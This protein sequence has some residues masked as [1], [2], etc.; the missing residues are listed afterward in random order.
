M[1]KYIFAIIGLLITETAFAASLVVTRKT[2]TVTYRLY[3][4]NT[5]QIYQ[6]S[7]SV[8]KLSGTVTIPSTI[9]Y[10]PD[11][12]V[13][14]TY[15]VTSLTRWYYGSKVQL[16]LPN[17][18]TNIEWNYLSSLESLNL[19]DNE[20]FTSFALN[21]I[22]S[23]D[24]DVL[25][26]PK[27][28]TSIT[29]YGNTNNYGQKRIAAFEVASDN[30]TYKAVNGVL[31]TKDG[32][33]LI[34]YPYR[35]SGVAYTVPSGVT[36]INNWAFY[37]ND[38]LET[39]ILPA[40]LIEI[41]KSAFSNCGNLYEC[42]LPSSLTKIGDYAFYQCGKYAEWGDFSNLSNL[43]DIGEYAFSQCKISLSGNTL[44]LP[45]NLKT[46]AKYSFYSAFKNNTSVSIIFPKTLGEAGSQL[47]MDSYAF[48]C[49]E[50]QSYMTD[51]VNSSSNAFYYSY[52]D[53]VKTIYIPTGTL[54]RY[55]AKT[56]WNYSV[57]NPSYCKLVESTNLIP[58][59]ERTGVPTFTW[60]AKDSILAIATTT[61]GADIYYTT[62]GSDPTTESTK[63]NAAKPI[64]A[65]VNMTV[66]AISVKAGLVTTSASYTVDCYVLATVT[67]SPYV[68]VAT[69]GSQV[70]FVKLATSEPDAKIYYLKNN[71]SGTPALTSITSVYNESDPPSVVNGN[72]VHTYAVKEGYTSTGVTNF[73][74]NTTDIT[75]SQP[76]YEYNTKD[77]GSVV[78]TFSTATEGATIYYTTDGNTPTT[79]STVY[80]STGI[81][82]TG[83]F[84]FKAIAAKESM[85]NSSV[86]TTNSTSYKT[87][88]ATAPKVQI[89]G[90]YTENGAEVMKAV[91]STGS[92]DPAIIAKEAY[93][94]RIGTSGPYAEY[95]APVTV[96]N[97]ERFYAITRVNNWDDS[98]S[99]TNP[100]NSYNYVYLSDIR[101]AQ[102]VITADRD[103]HKVTLTTT[104]DGGTIYYTTDGTVPTESSAVYNATTGVVLTENCAV[105]AMVAKEGM[106]HSSTAT[107]ETYSWFTCPTVDFATYIENGTAK[108]KLFLSDS[109]TVSVANM[110]IM[111]R[112]NSSYYINEYGT[113]YTSPIA[114]ESG[115]TVYAIAM[116][117]NFNTSSTTSKSMNYTTEGWKQMP[118]PTIT[119]D[120]K[121]KLVSIT[122]ADTLDIYYIIQ[123]AN[124]TV[125]MI[126]STSSTKYTA[127]FSVES[128]GIVKAVTAKTGYVNSQVSTWDASSWFRL[129]NVIYE[130]QYEQNGDAKT[131]K[132]KLSHTMDG[133]TIRYYINNSYYGDDSSTRKIYDGTPFVVNIGEYVHAM[134]FA[135][136]Q[137]DS[138]WSYS[139]IQEST[140]KVQT[141]SVTSTNSDTKKIVV[142]SNT[143]NATMYYYTVDSEG[144]SLTSG[145]KMASDTLTLSQND[146]L[147]FYAVKS[148]METS[149]TISYNIT[150][151]F[152][153][154]QVTLTPFV[155]DNKLKVRLTHSDPNATIYYGI[156]NYNSTVTSNLPYSTPIAV[157]DGDRIYASAAKDHFQPANWNYTSWLYYSNYTCDQ[158]TISID[159]D[160]LVSI[161]HAEGSTVYYTLDGSDPTTNSNVYSAPF[162]LTRNAT[163]KAM[164]TQAG[165]INSSIYTQEYNRFY[166]QDI[167]F[168]L[169]GT[170]MTITTSTPGTTIHYQ[171]EAEGLENMTYPHVYTG[172][173]EL[174]YNGYIY[175]QATKDGFNSS[176]SNYWPGNVVSCKVEEESFDG[177]LLKLKSSPGATIWY[178]TNNQRPYDN[179]NNWYDYVYKYESGIAIESTGHIKAIAT[180]PYMNESAVFD[181]E[182]SVFAGETGATTDDAGK[183]EASM[184]WA[185]PATI[186]EFT[187][188]GKVNAV[189]LAFIK[190]KMTSLQKL[191]LS[192]AK[193]E[194]DIPD[195][196]FAGMPLVSYASP[197]SITAV[198][199]KIFA[200]CKD[201]AA[202]EWN[203]SVRLPNSSFD[204]DVNPNLLLF[205][206]YETSAP[207]N[208]NVKNLIVNGEAALITL[209]DDENS[210][211]YCPREFRT[212]EISYTHDF[213]LTSGEGAGWEAIALPFDVQRVFHESKGDLLS[214]V[215]WEAQGRPES[216]KPYWLSEFTIDGFVDVTSI[217]ANKPYIVCMPNN[218]RYASRFRLGGKVTF[219]GANITVPVTNPVSA[220]RGNVT[221]TP[222]F[223]S[224]TTNGDV[225]ALNQN[226]YEG[227]APGSIFVNDSRT[228][229][230]FEAYATSVGAS[231]RGYISISE[232]RGQNGNDG[233]TGI[234]E[235]KI[236]ESDSEIVKV[237][238]LSGVLVKQCAK[239]DAL[240]GLAKGVYIVN[241][242]R[243]I[244]K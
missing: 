179:S 16:V 240:K 104:T 163:I 118:Q 162:K 103:N 234:E 65:T 209:V 156:G 214:F 5:A 37:D 134:A 223:Q 31:F 125:D 53:Y 27:G 199:E 231:T 136:G 167:A 119:H 227:H 197:T 21:K 24:I 183:L 22:T 11:G 10:T 91:V 90:S 155:E 76:T 87:F 229:R 205:L 239:E 161:A 43:T 2:G 123:P 180:A 165:K 131:Y 55:Q 213:K 175:V 26:L 138:E 102:P 75:C 201:L 98:N 188:D 67:V 200:G 44:T 211:F 92:T 78:L 116:K 174:E 217:Q 233:S 66:K 178:T 208:T 142:H 171:Y 202:V 52:S 126:P 35:K 127:P 1:K 72:Y 192:K 132:M 185:N 4:D 139:Y 198:G 190:D 108:M 177:H 48:N 244:V 32:K 128:N 40:G 113:E 215:A 235:R 186:T 51:P 154:D 212:K 62:D 20:S 13:E 18:I 228:I 230:P 130:P 41:E 196:A 210:N 166:V 70:I 36:T 141:P 95:T 79:A 9:T 195:E 157:S 99:W 82:V 57:S 111:Y 56:G 88:K 101:C 191:D 243:M 69:D 61:T 225:L 236:D 85:I 33:E 150:D 120:D 19:P 42:K 172:P 38:N 45:A 189:D 83:N 140:F 121:E 15:T 58:E 158:P 115:N 49:K 89:V 241:G 203:S 47:Y 54:S 181:R 74:I 145:T 6:D 133:V 193:M 81:V 30:D 168:N 17:T 14:T 73:Y 64:K 164:A 146:Y 238:N 219:Y 170:T 29:P 207:N 173:F 60:N 237:Y 124:S 109:T 77:D 147:K 204:A 206:Q 110:K 7:S 80:P 129:D 152:R 84:T 143:P 232:T 39:V 182:I 149:D 153:L 86:L 194:G 242:K 221:F 117:D 8:T 187:I 105:K 137:V 107:S 50:V 63:Y 100:N 71:S 169:D 96:N 112:L 23:C 106:L 94:Y 3:D 176:T 122:A 135:A 46:L 97:G 144:K 184:S 220:T 59:N 12:G 114:V 93:F 148:Q 216:Y 68:K 34:V 224:K 151:W 25:K 160:T 218:D 28:L 226:E 222:N 159:V